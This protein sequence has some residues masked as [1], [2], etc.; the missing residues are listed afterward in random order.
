MDIR[1]D[2]QKGLSYVELGRKYHLTN[3]PD[4][5]GKTRYAE[6][7]QKPGE[8]TIEKRTTR[9]PTK[10]KEYKPHTQIVWNDS[11]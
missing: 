3:G 1:S 7:P 8:L 2:R 4:R 6:S 11:G 10:P 9:S 5:D